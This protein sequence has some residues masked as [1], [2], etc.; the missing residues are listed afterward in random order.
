MELVRKR[1]FTGAELSTPMQPSAPNV[2]GK[3]TAP[4]D[5]KGITQD[6]LGS[7]SLND[8]LLWTYLKAGNELAYSVL[9]KRYVNRLYNYGMHSC[10]DCELVKNCLQET[11]VRIWSKRETLGAAVSV[12]H[13]LFKSFRSLL[14]ER[15]TANRPFSLAFQDR[16]SSSFEFISPMEDSTIEDKAKNQR[17]EVLTSSFTA[18]TK[19]QREAIF[20]KFFNELSYYEVSSIM[21][22]RVDSVYNLISKALDV[23]RTKPK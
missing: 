4:L 13:Y 12:K 10:K 16:L 5:K 9:Y 1:E 23:I 18:P 15:L 6:E 2:I 19:S 21:E 3:I 22:L 7:G 14:I 20:L 11:F 17:Q 8:E